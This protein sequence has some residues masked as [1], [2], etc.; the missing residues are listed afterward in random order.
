MK[1]LCSIERSGLASLLPVSCALNV[2]AEELKK[3]P[4]QYR[5]MHEVSSSGIV[6]ERLADL[7]EEIALEQQLLEMYHLSL[8]R[9]KEIFQRLQ[10]LRI[11]QLRLESYLRSVTH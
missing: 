2:Q 8:S 6:T 11:Y 10:A 7:K 3:E 1:Q 5:G 9:K 4:Y